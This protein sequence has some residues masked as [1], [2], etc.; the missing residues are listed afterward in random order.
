MRT[1]GN[2]GTYEAML[3]APDG[4]LKPDRR[5]AWFSPPSWAPRDPFTGEPP[6][7]GPAGDGQGPVLLNGRYVVREV[8]RHAFGGGVYRA[9]DERTGGQV[10]VK[11]ARP[12]TVA[13]LTGNDIRVARRHEARMLELFEPSGATA[14]L[15][16][17]FEQ[18][19]DLFLV[20]EAIPGV[21]L[22]QW[23]RDTIEPDDGEGW[24]LPR[25][26]AERIACG[27]VGL[28][29]LAHAKGLVHRDFNPNNIMVTEDGDL[30][31]IDLEMLATP[32]ERV[33][34]AYTPGYAAPEQVD[35]AP[36]C[37]APQRPPISTAWAPPC[38]TWSAGPTR[39]SSPTNRRRGR[40]R[41]ASAPGWATS[42]PRT[43]PPGGSP[44]SSSRCCTRTRRDARAWT[45]CAPSS[46]GRSDAHAW[47]TSAAPGRSDRTPVTCRPRG[48]A[49]RTWSG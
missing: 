30:R 26:T 45:T 40:V 6:D 25:E 2:D 16:E 29:E 3:V 27:L 17:V 9:T 20:Q 12:H 8:I 13:D 43:R 1:L 11:Q 31:L 7:Q 18:Q 22:R 47:T 10:V 46:P 23:V 49:P 24:G 15:V 19:G 33:S 4:S 39:C 28:V 37:A 21:T 5:Q 34:Q 36:I 48:P 44:R 41:S 32:G 35:A 42:P 14:R 38:S